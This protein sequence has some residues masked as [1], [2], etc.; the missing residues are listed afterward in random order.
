MKKFSTLLVIG[1]FAVV[2]NAQT[3]FGALGT[4]WKHCYAPIWELPPTLMDLTVRSDSAYVLSGMQ[5]NRLTI[6]D[7][8]MPTA[9]SI[10]VCTTGD[11]VY[12]LEQDSLFLLY[13]FSLGKGDSSQVRYPI[14][15]DTL[16]T[17]WFPNAS[18]YTTVTIDSVSYDTINGYA[19]KKQYI[20]TEGNPFIKFGNY[21]LERVGYQY[22]ILPFFSPDYAE[23]NMIAPLRFFDDGQVSIGSDSVGC[24]YLDVDEIYPDN[25]VSIFPNPANHKITIRSENEF[26]RSIE[27]ISSRGVPVR[28]IK[29]NNRTNLS[30]FLS[31]I[32]KGLYFIAVQTSKK[33]Y[34]KALILQ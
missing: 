16:F 1:F 11:K 3:H 26:I 6:I 4:T 20:T 10:D 9:S 17:A 33:V 23:V 8:P 25:V 34:W 14:K 27:I 29:A 12:Y 31:G 2:G 30:L 21:A 28:R 32:D 18:I 24:V 13:D 15:F 19:L 5:C 22:W 7:N